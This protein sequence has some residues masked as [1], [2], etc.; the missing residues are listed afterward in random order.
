[1]SDSQKSIIGYR[2]LEIEFQ[3]SII[4]NRFSEIDIWKSIL[5]NWYWKSI[6]R[7]RASEKSISGNRYL[8]I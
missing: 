1:M 5:G 8:E 4:A 6:F 3:K 2:A 7:N